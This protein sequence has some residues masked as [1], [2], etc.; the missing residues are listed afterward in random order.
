VRRDF[1]VQ[2]KFIAVQYSHLYCVFEESVR[3]RNRE[4]ENED[5][6][7]HREED[8]EGYEEDYE[9][10]YYDNYTQYAKDKDEEYFLEA[11]ESLEEIFIVG[12]DRNVVLRSL[13]LYMQTDFGRL[14]DLLK[15]I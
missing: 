2:V 12:K 13:E 14:T 9:V 15:E 11:F 6:A 5:H 7:E 8:E 3:R 4:Q 1:L 10:D